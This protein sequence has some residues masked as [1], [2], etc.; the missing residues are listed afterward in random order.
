[1]LS[2]STGYAVL[3]LACMI[4]DKQERFKVED[5]AKRA[6]IPRFTLHKILHDLGKSDFMSTKIG[7]RGG[8]ALTRSANQ[9][10]LLDIIDAVQ[11][12][13]WMDFCLLGFG[14]CSD[15]RNC[16]VHEKWS[17]EKERIRKL[18]RQVTL[19]QVAVFES[20]PGGRLK[21]IEEIQKDLNKRINN[22]ST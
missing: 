8:M 9:I 7:Y 18:M 12:E 21:S 3:A 17:V 5:I 13:K 22:K 1:M 16:P 19:D 2:K 15:E 4:T 6:D 10:T 20:K 14:G 11:G